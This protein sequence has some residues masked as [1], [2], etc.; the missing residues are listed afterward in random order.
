MPMSAR[1]EPR[2]LCICLYA[3]IGEFILHLEIST[4]K[5]P[6]AKFQKA[7]RPAIVPRQ[8]GS[9][10]GRMASVHEDERSGLPQAIHQVATA[11]AGAS[12]Q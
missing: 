2:Y 4:K 6:A 12:S 5:R 8:A 11:N 9:A 7:F 3:E 10:A 1:C